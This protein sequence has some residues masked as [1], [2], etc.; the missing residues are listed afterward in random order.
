MQRFAPRRC[1]RCHPFLRFRR[2]AGGI[3]RRSAFAASCTGIPTQGAARCP[4]CARRSYVHSPEHRGLPAWPALFTVIEI[5]TGVCHGSFDSEAEVA[6]HLI[7]A[8]LEH[9]QVEI[10]SDASAMTRYEAWS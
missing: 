1:Y 9:D 2:R 3:R 6:A 7:F 10:V 4:D 5:D 8:K